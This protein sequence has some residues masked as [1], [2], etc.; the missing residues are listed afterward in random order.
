M[1]QYLRENTQTRHND[2]AIWHDT[3]NNSLSKHHSNYKK[4][5]SP[6]QL[7]RELKKYPKIKWIVLC[8]RLGE[9][10]VLQQLCS[11]C[12]PTFNVIQYTFPNKVSADE[13]IKKYY[14]LH[15]PAEKKLRTLTLFQ[16]ML[17]NRQRSIV[18]ERVKT[19]QELI[20]VEDNS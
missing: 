3:I 7:V 6:K 5:L 9:P 11:S 20:G 15:Q 13:D 14:E 17:C 16:C 12:I 1:I 8:P 2:V 4:P 10:I 19:E 18:V